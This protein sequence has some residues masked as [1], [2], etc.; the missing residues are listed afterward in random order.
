M[1]EFDEMESCRSCLYWDMYDIDEEPCKYCYG[2]S[3]YTK[4]E[5]KMSDSEIKLSNASIDRFNKNNDK[6]MFINVY[7]YLARHNYGKIILN[8]E[9]GASMIVQINEPIIK[10]NLDD[11]LEDKR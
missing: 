4:K 2:L 9:N 3:L 1:F 6:E 8:F 11:I 5:T 10:L 7:N